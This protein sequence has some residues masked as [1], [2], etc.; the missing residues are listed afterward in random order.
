METVLQ[1]CAYIRISIRMLFI[2]TFQTT[3]I[4]F[5]VVLTVSRLLR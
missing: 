5:K 4:V 1:R 3:F 2:Y